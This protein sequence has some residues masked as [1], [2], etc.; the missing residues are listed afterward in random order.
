MWV[1]L[2]DN[3]IVAEGSRFCYLQE[4]A[5]KSSGIHSSLEKYYKEEAH[6]TEG[7]TRNT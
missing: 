1:H 3:I 7:L 5:L 4:L 6:Y 2:T